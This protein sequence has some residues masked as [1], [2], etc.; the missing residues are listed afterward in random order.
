MLVDNSCAF[1]YRK[2][3]C[4]S[5]IPATERQ[6]LIDLYNSTNGSGWTNK[7]NWLGA[8]GTE[9]TWYG[10]NC[11]AGENYVTEIILSNNNLSGTI[12]S[13]IVDFPNLIILRLYSNQL[14]GSILSVLGNLSNLTDL[15]LNSN[16]LSGT[17]PPEL[18]NLSICS[19]IL[20]NR[21]GSRRHCI[22]NPVY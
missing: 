10:V 2:F 6:A 4:V 16:Q 15:Q 17:I 18:G 8:S 11:D 22:R 9:C 3:A 21:N 7:T 19:C 20:C 1:F 13:S 14:S 12:P 5:R